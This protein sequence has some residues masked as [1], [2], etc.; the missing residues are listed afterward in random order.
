VKPISTFSEPESFGSFD[1][2][3]RLDLI[4][5]EKLNN[6]KETKGTEDKRGRFWKQGDDSRASL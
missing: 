1:Q 6:I 5:Q 3:R 2:I 4:L